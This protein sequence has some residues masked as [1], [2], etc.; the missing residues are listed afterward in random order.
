M[1]RNGKDAPQESAMVWW[2]VHLTHLFFYIFFRTEKLVQIKC[3][4]ELVQTVSLL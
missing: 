3:P 1:L 4:G 2:G